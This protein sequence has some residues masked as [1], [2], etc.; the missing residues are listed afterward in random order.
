MSEILTS[1][2]LRGREE[3]RAEGRE[4]GR[5]EGRAEGREEGRAE[6]RA[7]GKAEGKK[8]ALQRT[9]MKQAQRK[10]GAISPE[11]EKQILGSTSISRL[12]NALEYIFDFE[13]EEA[14]LNALKEG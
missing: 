13:N 5:A 4:E 3:G 2:H 6:G 7:E 14:L 10:L 8:E 1:Y 12:E 9:L 11:L